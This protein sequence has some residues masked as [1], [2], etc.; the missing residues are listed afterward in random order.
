MRKIEFF[1]LVLAVVSLAA[2]YFNSNE[3]LSDK[4]CASDSDCACGVNIK[5]GDCFFG[6]KNFVNVSRQCPDFC[7]G[8]AANIEIRCVNSTCV[9]RSVR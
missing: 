8:I 7:N 5:T 3:P 6:N 2:I 9:H 4:Y 1:L